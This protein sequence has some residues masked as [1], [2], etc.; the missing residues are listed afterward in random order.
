M[1]LSGGP[2]GIVMLGVVANQTPRRC[3]FWS[4]N[5]IDDAAFGAAAFGAA[6]FWLLLQKQHCFGSG[7]SGGLGISEQVNLKEALTRMGKTRTGMLPA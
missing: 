6:S 1:G 2:P 3:C 5:S 7:R 4:S